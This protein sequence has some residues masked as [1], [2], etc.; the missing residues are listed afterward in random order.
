MEGTIDLSKSFSTGDV[1]PETGWYVC[2]YHTY[3]QEWVAK[4]DVFPN[5]HKAN[6]GNTEWHPFQT[7]WFPKRW[8]SRI[9]VSPVHFIVGTNFKNNFLR[10]GQKKKRV[11]MC[12][13]QS[14]GARWV[15]NNAGCVAD[16][17]HDFARSAKAAR[18]FNIATNYMDK[19]Q[20]EVPQ[21]DGNQ[22]RF[23]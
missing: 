20:R 19:R 16:K 10:V 1:C 14:L 6:C 12:G 7:K 18:Q 22:K 23:P 5:C 11:C 2:K 17:G 3:I 15:Q 13:W 9:S 8:E 4:D 21:L